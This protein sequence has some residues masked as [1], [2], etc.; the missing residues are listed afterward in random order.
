VGE[1]EAAMVVEAAARAEEVVLVVAVVAAAPEAVGE[2]VTPAEAAVMRVA[3]AMPVVTEEAAVT[4]V[5][6][7]MPAAVVTAEAEEMRAGA[8]MAQVAVTLAARVRGASAALG[9]AEPVWV[10]AQPRRVIAATALEQAPAHP[11][12]AST[13]QAPVQ[14]LLDMPVSAVAPRPVTAPALLRR[15][16]AR[17]TRRMPRHKLSRMPHRPQWLGNSR[18]TPAHST[19][20]PA[21]TAPRRSRRRRRRWQTRRT[22]R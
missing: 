6:G 8:A 12:M 11:D 4:P 2:E 17:S 18:L 21:R 14:A 16:W 3:G 9:S 19:P 20:L 22:T 15:N 5:A 7:G 1:A 13:D 10:Q